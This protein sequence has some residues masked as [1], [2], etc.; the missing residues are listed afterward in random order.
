[1]IFVHFQV[2]GS[3]GSYC[4]LSRASTLPN[5]TDLH[6]F[7]EGIHP[8]WEVSFVLTELMQQSGS[9]LKRQ[10]GTVYIQMFIYH[11]GE[12]RICIEVQQDLHLWLEDSS[13]SIFHPEV[14]SISVNAWNW[15]M[16]AACS[17]WIYSDW[18]FS[19]LLFSLKFTFLI[20]SILRGH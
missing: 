6:L 20:R 3:W 5:P 11:F 19:L 2:E 13:T 15:Y 16:Y 8:L 18:S 12:Y 7:K 14:I 17:D 9:I 1:M 4:H 10:S